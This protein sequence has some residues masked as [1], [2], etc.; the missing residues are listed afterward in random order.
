MPL[1]VERITPQTN[2]NDARA[3]I[4]STIKQLM[5]E[6]KTQREAAGQAYGMAEERLGRQLPQSK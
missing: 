2:D 4:S 1:D 5:T 3:A 6:G